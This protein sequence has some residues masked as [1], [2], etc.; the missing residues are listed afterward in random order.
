MKLFPIFFD[1]IQY[2]HNS[3][4]IIR[5]IIFSLNENY[6][7]F[8]GNSENYIQNSLLE[9]NEYIT[10]LGEIHDNITA[11]SKKLL[12]SQQKLFNQKNVPFMSTFNADNFPDTI[13]YTYLYSF[14]MQT[15]LLISIIPLN[16]SEFSYSNNFIYEYLYNNLNDFLMMSIT[17]INE[18]YELS[19]DIVKSE[20]TFDSVTCFFIVFFI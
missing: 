8:E 20:I 18:F 11:K 19:Q 17:N 14:R 5:R 13:N 6:S 1:S 4:R 7:N 2:F 3:Q 10:Y 15:N 16:L 12:H 9:I